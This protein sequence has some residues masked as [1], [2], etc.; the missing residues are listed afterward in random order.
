MIAIQDTLRKHLSN[1]NC[2][3]KGVG[4][5]WKCFPIC[6]GEHPQNAKLELNTCGEYKQQY[7]RTQTRFC[8]VWGV[9]RYG[10]GPLAVQ[11]LGDRFSSASLDPPSARVHCT[12]PLRK[13]H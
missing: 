8:E 4:P 5:V 2:V 1:H 13:K 6:K 10:P 3:A 9:G 11:M 7:V 12:L